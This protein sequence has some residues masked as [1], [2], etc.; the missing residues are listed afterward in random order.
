MNAVLH[1]VS[2]RHRGPYFA[3]LITTGRPQRLKLV[4]AA[5]GSREERRPV[6]HWE[7]IG[8]RGPSPF[9][10]RRRF[11]KIA[12]ADRGKQMHNP[13]LV[14]AAGGPSSPFSGRAHSH[15]IRTRAQVTTVLST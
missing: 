8:T 3:A 10:A 15:G 1:S 5:A 12:A 2:F 13:K 11:A 7:I 6:W 9:R 4:A 14:R